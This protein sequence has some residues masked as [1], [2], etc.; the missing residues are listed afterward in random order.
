ASVEAMANAVQKNA[1][2]AAWAKQLAQETQDRAE[3]GGHVVGHAIG[4]MSEINVASRKIVDIIGV[5]DTIAF[6]TNLLA[7]NAAVEAARAGD[8]GRGFAV[9]AGEGRSLAGRAGGAAREIKQLI[10][11]SEGEIRTGSALADAAYDRM[12]ETVAA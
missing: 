4:A 12:H 11:S 6:Q 1:E 10:G 8:S 5:I 2:N 3:R 9:V 7:L